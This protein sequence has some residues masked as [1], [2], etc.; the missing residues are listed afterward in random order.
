MPISCSMIMIL[1]SLFIWWYSL[2]IRTIIVSLFFISYRQN[3][4]WMAGERF[5]WICP[6]VSY[7]V[8]DESL[9]LKQVIT[10]SL[11]ERDLINILRTNFTCV[12]PSSLWLPANSTEPKKTLQ[13]SKSVFFI[14]KY[15]NLLQKYFVGFKLIVWLW[16]F[17]FC[18]VKLRGMYHM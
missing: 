13:Q 14:K 9:R 17:S 1:R 8:N 3:T 6:N 16:G 15:M 11:Q 5:G 18:K 4:V 7:Q 10:R 12:I 2:K